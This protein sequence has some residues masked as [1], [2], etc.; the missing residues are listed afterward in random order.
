MTKRGKKGIVFMPL[1]ITV[2]MF[3]IFNDKI[4]SQPDE[5]GF[6]MI[7]TLGMSIGLILRSLFKK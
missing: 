3:V 5:A 2:A 4:S 6:W 7:L 1:V